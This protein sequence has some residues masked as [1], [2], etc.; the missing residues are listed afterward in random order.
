MVKHEHIFTQL[1]QRIVT[2]ELRPGQALPS[3]ADLMRNHGVALGTVRQVLNRLQ[4]EG[5]VRSYRGKG[6]FV[7]TRGPQ[8]SSSTASSAIGLAAF[9]GQDVTEYDH[10]MAMRAVFSKA[11]VELMVG[12]FS[13]SQAD[14]AL[15]WAKSM[16]GVMTWG[17]PPRQFTLRLLEE[18][19]PTILLGNMHEEDCPPQVS[20]VNFNLSSAVDQVSQYLSGM[21]HRRIL[22]INRGGGDVGPYSRFLNQLS[23]LTAQAVKHRQ[24]SAFFDELALDVGEVTR[25]IQYMKSANPPPTALFFEG[26]QRACR[27]LHEL[28]KAG[29][30]APKRISVIGISPLQPRQIALPDLSYVELPMVELA[31]RGSEVMLELLRDRRIV[32]EAISPV[33]HWGKTCQSPDA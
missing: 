13:P 33:L 3:Q 24:P 23:T 16:A 11:N 28:E 32:R 20:L 6:S 7:R 14:E 2:G 8:W 19:V 18:N 31:T 26:G 12:V 17:Q 9:G 27:Y 30:S 1:K 5:W 15:E 22:F 4:S 21:G 25:L 29:W 10:L